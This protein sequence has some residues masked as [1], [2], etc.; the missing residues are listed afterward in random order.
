MMGSVSPCLYSTAN[1]PTPPSQSD[2]SV[3]ILWPGRVCQIFSLVSAFSLLS[4]ISTGKGVHHPGGRHTASIVSVSSGLSLYAA[5]MWCI[6]LWCCLTP[7]AARRMC[8]WR[9]WDLGSVQSLVALCVMCKSTSR[10]KGG[11]LR[12]ASRM[13]VTVV[14][15]APVIKM[16]AC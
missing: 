12:C 5:R 11:R 1:A 2:P 4:T 15:M 13:S 16:D 7:L 8:G 6:G 9:G 3:Y 10:W 14:H